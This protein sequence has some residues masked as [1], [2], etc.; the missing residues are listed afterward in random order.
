MIVCKPVAGLL[1][2]DHHTHPLGQWQRSMNITFRLCHRRLGSPCPLFS[3]EAEPP[4]LRNVCFRIALF[5]LAS[6]GH[7][8]AVVRVGVFRIEANGCSVE[9]KVAEQG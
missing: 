6:T 3:R 7:A 2:V 8:T 1:A 4:G 9:I 5:T